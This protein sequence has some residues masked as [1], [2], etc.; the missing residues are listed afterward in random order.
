MECD[1]AFNMMM[2]HMDRTLAEQDALSLNR[3]LEECAS[4]AEDFYAYN[5]ILS[6]ISVQKVYSPPAGFEDAVMEKI[7]E[8][9]FIRPVNAVKDSGFCVIWSFFSA[10]IG[11]G[12]VLI[13]YKDAIIERFSGAGWFDALVEALAPVAAYASSGV[14]WLISIVEAMGVGFV[15]FISPLRA[16]LLI[17]CFVLAGAQY[18]IAYGKNKTGI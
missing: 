1:K 6:E 5:K 4:C 14:A 15:E 13:M 7:R 18:F 16:A 10:F 9:D 2:Q 12:F 3:H 17:I 8:L 11:L